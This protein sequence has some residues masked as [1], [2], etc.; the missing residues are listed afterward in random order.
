MVVAV[1]AINLGS[2]LT[3]LIVVRH[4]AE[5][6]IQPMRVWA[7]CICSRWGLW[8]SII[9]HPFAVA[10]QL[11]IP[12]S[13]HIK[14]ELNKEI[15]KEQC[16]IKIHQGKIKTYPWSCDRFGANADAEPGCHVYSKL[17]MPEIPGGWTRLQDL[18]H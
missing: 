8:K 13:V 15:I 3:R 16:T 5:S 1:H 9:S 6:I 12:D 17:E 7:D 2:I 10:T 4:R 14:S 11:N 18:N